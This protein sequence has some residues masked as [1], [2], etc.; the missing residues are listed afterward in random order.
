MCIPRIPREPFVSLLR[1]YL[2]AQE[3]TETVSGSGYIAQSLSPLRVL[4]D[5]AHVPVPTMKKWLRGATQ[6]IEFDHAD[7]VLCAMGTPFPFVP[8]LHDVYREVDLALYEIDYAERTR[9][10]T[11]EKR[12]QL[13]R[14]RM[15]A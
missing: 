7:R 13:A 4:A 15:A 2:D 8:E 14:V 1:E 5:E 11:R 6:R 3:M 10:R 12:A 9:R